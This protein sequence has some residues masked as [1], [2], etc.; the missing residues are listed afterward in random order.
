D[1]KW[2]SISWDEA[3][4]TI[5]ERLK[6]IRAQDTKRLAEGRGIAGQRQEGWQA[7]LKAFGPVQSL[8]GGRSTR[9]DQPEHAFAER[10][11]GGFQCEP[12]MEYCNYLILFGSNASASGGTV[13]GVLFASAR[14]RG[15]KMVAIDPV[16]SVTAAKAEEWM[17]IRPC[18]DGAFLLAMV[19][20][21]IHELGVW[22]ADFLKQMTNSPYLVQPD[23]YFMRDKANKVLV[24]DP[25]DQRTKAYDDPT[26]RDFA[27]EGTYDV[28]GVKCKPAFQLLKEHVKQ[29]TPEW[30]AKITDVSAET[31][32][33]IT[34]TFV[35]NA[36]IGSTITI[37]GLTLPYRPAATKL[38][39]GITGVMRSYQ[40]VL[41]NHV[42][43]AL[44]G[45]IEVPG[46]HMGGSTFAHGKVR[47]GILWKLY[48]RDGG[49]IPGPDGMQEVHRHP[50][51][52]PPSSYSAFE[53]LV[54][55]TEDH[56]YEEPP[57]N[58]P[59]GSIFHMDHLDWKNLVAPPKGLPVP[60][61]PEMWI[62]YRTN[63]LLTLGEPGYVEEAMRKIPFIVS[64]SYTE[65][66]VTDFADILLPEE[67]ELERY[68]PC[69]N[70]RDACQKKFFLLA[71][72]QP[73]VKP[74][75]NIR[76]VNDILAELAERA[77]FL[78]EYNEAMNKIMCLTGE[79]Q[80]GPDKRYSWMESVDRMCQSYTSGRY[81]L[82][83]F[84]KNGALVKPITVEDQYDI[85]LGMKAQKLRY[86]IPYMEPVKRT[87]E[88]LARDLAKVG[89]DWWKTE[90]YTA[91][92]TYFPS[93]LEEVPPQY[94]FYVTTC[95]CAMFGY[96]A[97]VGIPWMNE[98]SEHVNGVGDILMNADAAKARGIKEGDEI[99]VESE[100]GK[101][102]SK[103]KLCQGIRP[104]TLLIAGQFGQWAMPVAKDTGR[105]TQTTLLPVSYDWTDPVIGIQQGMVVKARVYRA[106]EA[107]RKHSP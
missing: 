27:L 6:K 75:P 69:F 26:V 50:F 33:R 68:V 51:V 84:K 64:I 4:D 38:G 106:Q 67:V 15:M 81:D 74:L 57:Y 21:V 16:L 93:K 7:F 8:W 31:I 36:R 55:L 102:R 42:L 28:E 41:A 107:G 43:A 71:M 48:P 11:H 44:V 30:A 29:Y 97:N 79:Y 56:P 13:E 104:D 1:P 63:P 10:I 77:G 14:D 19:N 92:P 96:G 58:D 59:S 76:N 47:E 103:V 39:R 80:L 34:R 35:E 95:R 101:V 100:V 40:A 20:V 60:A 62:R 86:P 32:R 25:L 65:D 88:E 83:W 18:T 46:G 78:N 82:D 49:V 99:F 22:D 91:L 3:L 53:I 37:N 66:E 72:E 9:C 54:P 105:V 73:V 23:G 24:W 85:H 45:S 87:G 52:W 5:A 17:P 70:N 90:E 89:I 12:D 94:D 2:V 61:P 98:I